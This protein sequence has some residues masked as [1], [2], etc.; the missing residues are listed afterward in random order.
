MFNVSRTLI[1]EVLHKHNITTR[2][3]SFHTMKIK[4]KKEGEVINLYKKG[5]TIKAIANQYKISTT[6]IKRVLRKN[7]ISI[8]RGLAHKDYANNIIG[9]YNQ[10]ISIYRLSKIFNHAYQTIKAILIRNNVELR[11]KLTYIK[12]FNEKQK[13]QIINLHKQNF[14]I[15]RI[16]KMFHTSYSVVYKLINQNL[17]LDGEGSYR[18]KLPTEEILEII[19]LFKRGMIKSEIAEMFMITKPMLSKILGNDDENIV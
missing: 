18:I 4:P 19:Y 9:F 6:G 8:I 13:Q 10:G 2:H 7:N 15:F 12:E 11:K 16:S 17:G 3:G 14:S 5:L 1:S